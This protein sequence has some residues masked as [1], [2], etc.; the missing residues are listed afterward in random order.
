MMGGLQ[1]E[2]LQRCSRE[3]ADVFSLPP[4]QKIMEPPARR[5]GR[6]PSTGRGAAAAACGEQSNQ[7][8]NYPALTSELGVAEQISAQNAAVPPSF[9]QTALS[10][11]ESAGGP[12]SLKAPDQPSASR[13]R[14]SG[15]DTRV[16]LTWDQPFREGFRAGS[17]PAGPEEEL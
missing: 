10:P 4:A 12:G 9:F 6:G 13:Q 17:V 8:R 11:P 1:E 16:I 3:R 2:R 5:R 14:C 7:S 15:E